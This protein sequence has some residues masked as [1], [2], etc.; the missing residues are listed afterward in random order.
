MLMF[1]A[2]YDWNISTMFSHSVGVLFFVI[3]KG[4]KDKV[5]EREEFGDKTGQTE[6]KVI[7]VV[8]LR[9]SYGFRCN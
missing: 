3:L 9:N 4:S 8:I 7:S 1:L 5:K 2:F 6:C